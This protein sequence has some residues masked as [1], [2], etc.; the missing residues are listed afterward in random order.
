M[1]IDMSRAFDTTQRRRILKI[2][3]LTGFSDDDLRMV[4]LVAAQ[5]AVRQKTTRPDPPTSIIGSYQ[6][7]NTQTMW[8]LQMK[9][10]THWTQS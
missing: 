8:T 1:G 6:S 7:E 5:V 4:R 10:E 2:I 3:H 9:S